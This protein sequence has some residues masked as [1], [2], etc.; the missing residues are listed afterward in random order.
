MSITRRKL[1]LDCRARRKKKA[2]GLKL[3]AVEEHNKVI[4]RC[5][6]DKSNDRSSF[7][8]LHQNPYNLTN[9][10]LKTFEFGTSKS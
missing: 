4:F 7:N 9:I 3:Q 2:L 10:S 1:F 6:I 8:I 5:P